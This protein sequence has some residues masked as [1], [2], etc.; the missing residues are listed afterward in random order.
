M[1]MALQENKSEK[2]KGR[3]SKIIRI[4]IAVLGSV[5][6]L[7]MGLRGVMWQDFFYSLQRMR[8]WYVFLS[9]IIIFAAAAFSA[10]KLSYLWD[11]K[12]R[13]K[14]FCASMAANAFY[15]MPVGSVFGTG[16]LVKFL[17]NSCDDSLYLIGSKISF[18]AITRLLDIFMVLFF[19]VFFSSIDL[20][21]WIYVVSILL[22]ILVSA[23]IAIFMREKTRNML[24]NLVSPLAKY[25][26]GELLLDSIDAVSTV[27][28]AIS[29]RPMRLIMSL[30]MGAISRILFAIPF[31]ILSEA[32]GLG[33]S[34]GDFLW[35]ASLQTFALAL[36]FSIG[37]LGAREG[38]I[39]VLMSMLG[40]S[41]T[42][43]VTLSLVYSVLFLFAN[44]AG[45]VLLPGA[46][47]TQQ[48]D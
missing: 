17:S 14:V 12:Y 37:G 25:R 18:D 9:F 45:I 40:V 19:S 21:E 26:W 35:I 10:I 2:N 6:L 29:E 48:L 46:K 16:A 30:F 27:S 38:A 11:R 34:M 43:A 42:S 39:I 4:M 36:P 31:F 33:V 23:L 28:S 5:V 44:I 22:T 3:S 32:L 41:Q 24:K 8:K 13:K 47:M 1:E 20:P 7:Y 15:V